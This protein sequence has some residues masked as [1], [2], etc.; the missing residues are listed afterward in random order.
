MSEANRPSKD[1]LQRL[2]DSRHD[3][4]CP[5]LD[6]R[7]AAAVE[8]ERLTRD[9]EQANAQFRE[10]L[11]TNGSIAE[12]NLRLSVDNKRRHAALS[13]AGRQ[14]YG[15]WIDHSAQCEAGLE[16]CSC[17]CGLTD[18]LKKYQADLGIRIPALEAAPPA[19][20]KAEQC[21]DGK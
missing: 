21:S 19:E 12:R 2:R 4:V 10:L 1:V 18:W 17:T 15:G 16:G 3:V 20:T 9:L 11:L 6:L 7:D 5:C 14:V 13:E 8:I